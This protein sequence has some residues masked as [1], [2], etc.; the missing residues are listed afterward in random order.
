L[1]LVK[2]SR[3]DIANA[4]R[5]LSKMM[6][7]PTPAAMKELKRVIKFV[8][9]TQD[10]GLKLE[11][12][13]MI[14][15]KW[16]LKVYT[17]SD[18]AGDKDTRLSVTGYVLFLMNVPILWK[19]KAQK[20]LA[21]SSSEAEYYAL[22]E[23]AKDIKFVHML[24]TSMGMKVILPIVVK[25]DNVGAIFMTENISTSGRTKHLDLRTRYV[26]T[27]AE[28]GF[29]KFEFVRS[30]QNKSDHLTKNVT[31]EIYEAHVND[32]VRSK[33]TFEQMEMGMI[34]I[35][36][37]E[38]K[39]EV[40]ADVTESQAVDN[41][42]TTASKPNAETTASGPSEEEKESLVYRKFLMSVA[43][44]KHVGRSLRE[45]W[46]DKVID[47]F[48]EIDITSVIDVVI[49][50]LDINRRLMRAG[51]NPMFMDTLKIMHAFGLKLLLE[52][53]P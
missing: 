52:R 25:V 51:R 7:G 17:D 23:A 24:L 2:H 16:I 33:R 36:K 37:A 38:V 34:T 27:M 39:T 11:P 18:W 44:E 41:T 19:S 53:K 20:S 22:S 4:V 50:I 42:E 28:E 15:N 29:I 31:G 5:E 49:N 1:F 35:D 40:T 12:E 46:V 45:E 9:D 8:L 47:K 48:M 3:P 14:E 10:Y 30:A 26:N 13:K 43:V 32:Y 21:L 6:D